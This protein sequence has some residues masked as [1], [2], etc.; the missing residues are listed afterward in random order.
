[1]GSLTA[2][3]FSIIVGGGGIVFLGTQRSSTDLAI[4]S[5][6]LAAGLVLVALGVWWL[7]SGANCLKRQEF[8]GLAAVTGVLPDLSEPAPV[9]QVLAALGCLNDLA[10]PYRVD[11]E[12]EKDGSARVVARLRV[13]EARW[14][15]VMG[16]GELRQTWCLRL[17][18]TVG[19]RYRW[20]EASGTVTSS[21]GLSGVTLARTGF[22]G[23][24]IGALSVRAVFAPLGSVAGPGAD[25]RGAVLRMSPSDVKI[26]VF[27]VLRAYGW[28]PR[29][30]SWLS[31]IWEY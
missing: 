1:M 24:T 5:V 10:L 14:R 13:E 28:R 6:M 27:R 16:W 21:V 7:R 2:L 11:W 12:E 29:W 15:S 25:G 3:I 17:T 20:R 22:T 23:K 4:G 18:L 19:G 31:Q 30:D 9:G 26:P 8:P